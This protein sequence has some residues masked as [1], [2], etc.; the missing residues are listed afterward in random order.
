MTREEKI[1]QLATEIFEKAKTTGQDPRPNHYVSK[2]ALIDMLTWSNLFTE[3]DQSE[4]PKHPHLDR[5]HTDHHPNSQPQP[6][7]TN[8][9]N[10]PPT[11][12]LMINI[13][14]SHGELVDKLTILTIKRNNIPDHYKLKNITTEYELLSSIY[15]TLPISNEL[16]QLQTQLQDIN[17]KIWNTEDNIRNYENKKDFSNT[18]TQLARDIY[19]NNDKRAQIKKKINNL[20]SSHITEEKSYTKYT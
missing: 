11:N 6:T 18:F 5:Q 1:N 13:P 14:V 16:L 7:T 3:D 10:T 20:F 17:Q 2:E 4:K 19:I 9:N 15:A 8:N 12:S